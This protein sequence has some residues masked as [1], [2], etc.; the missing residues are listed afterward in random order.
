[1]S[2]VF[3][4]PDVDFY[5]GDALEVLR[6]LGDGCCSG[7]VT[8]PPYLDSRP[9]YP[10][11]SLEHFADIFRELRR[12]V[13]GPLLLNVGRKWRDGRE[14]RWYEPLIEMIERLDGWPLVDT[15]IWVKPNANPILGQVLADSH[16]YV[17]MFGG[18]FDPDAVR[19]EYASSSISRANRKWLN[20]SGVKGV[21]RPQDG[22]ELNEKG[23]RPRSFMVA[24]VGEE[25]GLEHPAPMPLGIAEELVKLS[26]ALCV[27]DPFAG[28]ATTCLAARNLGRR[29]IGIELLPDHAAMAAA[30]LQQLALDPTLL[31]A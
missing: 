29:S 10:S 19:T 30:R 27:M 4:D 8:S 1:M 9:E 22:R 24:Y 31:P 6:T 18:P 25:K 20:G 3:S 21:A 23:A 15:R 11:P 17:L 5:C 16:E 12:V 28:G 13:A 26:G 7:C 2:A 14:L